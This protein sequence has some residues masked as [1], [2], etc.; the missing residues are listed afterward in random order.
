[1]R[2]GFRY[3]DP[4]R[5][6][7]RDPD[8]LARIKRL[9][10]P[11]AWNEV[12]ISPQE[13]GHIQATGRDARGRKQYRYHARWRSVRDETKFEQLVG[14]AREVLPRVRERVEVDLAR[15]GMPREKVLAT[16]VRLLDT[17]FMR[18]GNE[19]YARENGSFGLTTLHIDH[20]QVNAAR[21]RFRFRGKSG[22]Q[23]D[24]ALVDRRLARIVRRCRDLPGQELFQY[25][26]E[27][28][29]AHQIGSADVNNYLRDIT[30]EETLLEQRQ[31]WNVAKR[32]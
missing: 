18:V 21:L 10:I 7:L 28:G 16:V 27:N 3:V 17:T 15:P 22:Q 14:F 13:N 1:M 12:W 6:P 5:K 2:G 9:A 26:D 29:E 8:V 24:I 19:A 11:P 4:A 30:G 25:L 23:H 31:R 32:R 20:V